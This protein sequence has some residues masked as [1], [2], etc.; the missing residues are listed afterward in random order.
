VCVPVP[1]RNACGR[2]PQWRET[3]GPRS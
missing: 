3:V 2:T 1:V